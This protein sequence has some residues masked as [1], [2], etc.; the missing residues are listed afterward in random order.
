MGWMDQTL[1]TPFFIAAAP[2]TR[3]KENKEE[4]K[5]PSVWREELKGATLPVKQDWYHQHTLCTVW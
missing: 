4:E 3:I 1:L 2:E 5:R